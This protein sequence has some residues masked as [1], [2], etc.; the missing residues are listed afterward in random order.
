MTPI[1]H[2][3]LDADADPPSATPAAT[4]A[5][6]TDAKPTESD[7]PGIAEL[8]ARMMGAGCARPLPIGLLTRPA[9]RRE[10]VLV[11]RVTDENGNPKMVPVYS[12]DSWTP[13]KGPDGKDLEQQETIG[14]LARGQLHMIAGAGGAGKGRWVMGVAL[15][16]ACDVSERDVC[17]LSVVKGKEQERVLLL[18]GEDDEVDL[19]IRTEGVAQALDLDDKDEATMQ[20][21]LVVEPTYGLTFSICGPDPDSDNPNAI[22]Q[23]EEFKWLRKYIVD[24]GPWSLI[25]IDPMSRFTG[26]DEND[27]NMQGE[28][29]K[30]LESLCIVNGKGNPQPA[31]LVVD[32]TR[33]QGSVATAA[34]QDSVRGAGAKVNAARCVMVLNKGGVKRIV[35]SEGRDPTQSGFNPGKGGVADVFV[36]DARWG[37]ELSLIHI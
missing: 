26:V 8:K 21:K 13:L 18:L 33:K 1:D 6:A 2:D 23:T 7:S 28:V 35:D 11:Q 20:R 12:P 5:T 36:G 19:H 32:H 27:N 10:H 30:F 9:P 24:N 17:G 22:A 14:V 16:V 3:A 34:T 25:A 31:V 15:G 29:M 37:V 4:T